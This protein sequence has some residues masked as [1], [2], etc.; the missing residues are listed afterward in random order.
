MDPRKP[1]AVLHGGPELSEAQRI[2]SWPD[3]RMPSVVKVFR[4][5]RHDHFTR[6]GA[7]RVQEDGE[8]HVF[9]WSHSTFV[10]E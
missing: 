4:G 6:T 8:L 1:T 10:A 5:N 7:K 2:R 3:G 9:E